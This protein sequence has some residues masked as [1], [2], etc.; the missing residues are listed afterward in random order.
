M[1]RTNTQRGNRG[2]KRLVRSS[3]SKCEILWGKISDI[4]GFKNYSYKDI[5]PNNNISFKV[6]SLKNINIMN[7]SYN[8]D[9]TA[10]KEYIY[11][12]GAA[13]GLAKYLWKNRNKRYSLKG[14]LFATGSGAVK[15]VVSVGLGRIIGYGSLGKIGKRIWKAKSVK[16][17]VKQ[18]RHNVRAS[19][20]GVKKNWKGHLKNSLFPKSYKKISKKVS[21]AQKQMR[22]KKRKKKRR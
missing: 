19:I 21:K 5:F 8:A 11:G 1:G 20:K 15:G 18:V 4:Y 12:V 13:N 14:A 22:K 3:D 17:G 2:K 16:K 9:G 6:Y 7:F 10:S